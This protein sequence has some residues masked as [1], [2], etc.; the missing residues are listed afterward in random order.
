LGRKK[1]DVE[2]QC[3]Y[4]ANMYKSNSAYTFKKSILI[5]MIP[6][7]IQTYFGDT[8]MQKNQTPLHDIA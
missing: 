4:D 6:N 7:V 1:K 2:T 8:S 5:L 3:N